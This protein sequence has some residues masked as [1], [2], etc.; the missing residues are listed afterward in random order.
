M[1]LDFVADAE[2]PISGPI[3]GEVDQN[4]RADG[5]AGEAEGAE[6]VLG[7][8]AEAG[9]EFYGEQIK[10]TFD[11]AGDA[12]F[13]MA[14]FAGAV[15]DFDLADAVA[16]AGGQDGHEAVQFAVELDFVEDL[17]AVA[18]HPAVVVVELYARQVADHAVEDAGGIDFVPGVVPDALP[19]ADDVEIFLH[20]GEKTG[21]FVRVVLEVGVERHDDLA[22]RGREARRERGGLAEVASE[23]DSV[24]AGVFFRQPLD[25]LP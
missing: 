12:V 13:G 4:Q 9:E 22:A 10:K 19:A 25:N 5:E 23:A 2:P 3:A 18:F 24:D 11:E 15:R 6:D 1:E 14:E 17:A 8:L 20:L 7:T 21:D 16:A